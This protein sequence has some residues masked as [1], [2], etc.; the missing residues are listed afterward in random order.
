MNKQ[1]RNERID[2]ATHGSLPNAFYS[3]IDE[4]LDQGYEWP[5]IQKYLQ[6]TYSKG[7]T[8]LHLNALNKERFTDEDWVSET[9]AT[10]HV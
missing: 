1:E 6:T 3:V 4:L 7:L 10:A 5:D 8:Y 2:N 9:W